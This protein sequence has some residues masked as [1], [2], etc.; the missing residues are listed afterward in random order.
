MTDTPFITIIVPFYNSGEYINNSV[1]SIKKQTSKNFEVLFVNDGSTD[2]SKEILKGF[3]I[4]SDINY[5]IIDKEN[6][7]ASSAR[8]VGIREAKGDYVFFLDSDDFIANELIKEVNNKLENENNS[9]DIIYWGWDKVN[10]ERVVLQKYEDRYTYIESSDSFLIDYMLE[11][12]WIWTG[13]ATYRKNF[14]IENN[15]FFPEGIVISEDVVFIFTTLL[16]AKIIKCIPKS[17]SFYCIHDD[18]ISRK[19]T[20]KRIYTI[21]AMYLLEKLLEDGTQEKEIFLNKFKPVF[22]WNMI[23][24]L[25]LFDRND[26][27]TRKRIIRLLK[28]N[29]IRKVL[30]KRKFEKTKSKI[31]KFL[32]LYFPKL[33]IDYIQG[34]KRSIECLKKEIS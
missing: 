5:R 8:N 9:P 20:F 15:I 18:S 21:K 16:K 12:F 25:L 27:K 26:H 22:Y 3:L 29:Y 23:D 19:Y 13:S 14:L 24:V 2:N 17:L 6:G 34:M 30:K 10:N 28:N 1:E 11:R 4:D 31:R 33:Y 7:G 32:I